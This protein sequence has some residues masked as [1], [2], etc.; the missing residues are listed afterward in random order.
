[1]MLEEIR[2]H[3]R[4]AVPP[5]QFAPVERVEIVLFDDR[6]LDAFKDASAKMTD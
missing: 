6:A 4:G 2:D 3:L 5:A 1:V